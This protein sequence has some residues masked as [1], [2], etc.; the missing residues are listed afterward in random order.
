MNNGDSQT[1]NI[2]TAT[3]FRTVIIILGLVF[4]Y[5]IRDIVLIV[6]VSVIIA[7]AIN[8]PVSW[9]QRHKVPRILGVIFIYLLLFLLVALVITLIFPPLA[10]QVKQL[11]TH[12]PEFMEK[13]SLSF[14]ELWG[15]Y[16]I[17]GNLQTFLDKLGNRLNQATSSVFSTIIGIFGGLFSAGVVLVISFYLAVQEKGVKRFLISLTPSE[18]QHYLS[19]LIE[20]IQGKIGGWLR[21]QLLL[22][23]IVGVL[24]YIGL[25]FLGVKYALTLALVACLFELIPYIGPFIALVPASI[26]A[27]IQSPFLALLVIILYIVIQQLENYVI[28][29]QVMKKTV[30]LNPIVII[31]VMLIG[32]K[33]AGVMG[34]ILSV[35]LAASIGEFLKD[36]NKER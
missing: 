30:G 17:E 13:A 26:L 19:D 4:L 3:I 22:M 7:A 1:I 9:M 11:A 35:P 5:L 21:G 31:I 32:A 18:H 20:R 29:P 12:F 23:L 10:A 24:T 27:F 25:Y 36:L 15:K 6:F 16:K 28:Y 34:I 14:Q 33:L 8:G 2:S